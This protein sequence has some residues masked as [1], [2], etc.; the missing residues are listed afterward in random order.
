MSANSRSKT[1]NDSEGLVK[2]LGD[3]ETDRI[4]GA[5]IVSAVRHAILICMLHPVLWRMLCI[6]Q[7]VLSRKTRI[8]FFMKTGAVNVRIR[9]ARGLLIQHLGRSLVTNFNVNV[10]VLFVSNICTCYEFLVGS[11]NIHRI[12]SSDPFQHR[13]ERLTPLITCIIAACHC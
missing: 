11:S 12:H 2:I 3:K 5:H 1:N 4:L 10:I 7:F 8:T 13:N 6:H 9:L